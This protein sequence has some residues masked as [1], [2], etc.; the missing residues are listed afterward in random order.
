M[1]KPYFTAFAANFDTLDEDVQGKLYNE[2]VET[3]CRGEKLSEEEMD[4]ITSIIR[5][6]EQNL[7]R[8]N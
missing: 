6:Y 8:D 4:A 2:A 3:R 1:N 7:G 5:M